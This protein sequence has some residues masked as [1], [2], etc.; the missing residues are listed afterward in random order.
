MQTIVPV[1]IAAEK[2]I[3]R[4]GF[5]AEPINAQKRQF[6]ES[7]LAPVSAVHN[8]ATVYL[9]SVHEPHYSLFAAVNVARVPTGRDQSDGIRLEKLST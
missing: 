6:G 5:T 1:E 8:C 7:V 4:L 9:L 3:H 2:F